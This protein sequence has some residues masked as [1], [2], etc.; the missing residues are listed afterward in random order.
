[1][2]KELKNM[3]TRYKRAPEGGLRLI[4]IRIRIDLKLLKE[5]DIM[6]ESEL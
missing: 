5:E 2:V 6:K 3:D 1:M 4:F